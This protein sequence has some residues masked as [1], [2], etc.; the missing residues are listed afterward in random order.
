MANGSIQVSVFEIVILSISSCNLYLNS[1]SK[2]ES[3]KNFPDNFG[4]GVGAGSDCVVWLSPCLNQL[5][6]FLCFISSE[7][8]TSYLNAKQ[9][10]QGETKFV[11]LNH[12]FPLVYN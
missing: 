2:G 10:L 5:A 6:N 3:L 9:L 8:K 7:Q 11:V 12:L 4:K 1:Q